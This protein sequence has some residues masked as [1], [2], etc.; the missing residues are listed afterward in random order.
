VSTATAIAVDVH[1]ARGRIWRAAHV[2]YG[3]GVAAMGVL[4]LLTGSLAYLFQPVP[5]W[6]PLRQWV[7]YASGALLIASGLAL[8]ARRTTRIAA[9]VLTVNFAFFW[10]LLLHVPKALA[11]PMV[12]GNWEGCGLNMAVVAG[13]WILLALSSPPPAGPSARLF[14]ESGVSLARRVYALGLPL[15]G[16]AHF[17]EARG[18]TEY[19][20]TWFPLPIGWVYLTGTAHFAAGLAILFGV[21]PALAAVLEASQITAFVILAH[22]PAVYG[23]PHDKEQWGQLLYAVAICGSAWLVAATYGDR[24]AQRRNT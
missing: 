16:L 22:I 15:V 12:V 4:C 18:A 7:A 19:V 17:V 8:L 5:R 21:L 2:A 11:E 1:S 10:L 6:V 23:A 13:T 9:L 24:S 3:V 14:G 20:P